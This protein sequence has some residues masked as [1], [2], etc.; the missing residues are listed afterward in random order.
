MQV[1]IASTG[2]SSQNSAMPASRA[3]AR[4]VPTWMTASTS[5]PFT[6]RMAS[7]SSRSGTCAIST[8]LAH[9]HV[10]DCLQHLLADVLHQLIEIVIV[11]DRIV[12]D[13]DAAEVIGDAARPHGF[14]LRLHGGVGRGRDHAEFLAEAERVGHGSKLAADRRRKTMVSSSP[15]AGGRRRARAPPL[16]V[17]PLPAA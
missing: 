15:A 11:A 13:V 12:G 9:H 1:L 7:R 10:V 2:L 6:S 5:G 14:E 3:I 4:L 8:G 17:E 16:R